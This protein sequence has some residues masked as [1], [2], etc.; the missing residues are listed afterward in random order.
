MIFKVALSNGEFEFNLH[1]NL[2]EAIEDLVDRNTAAGR[3][4]KIG[5]QDKTLA[6]FTLTYPSINRTL[7]GTIG[8][9]MLRRNAIDPNDALPYVPAF[10]K[11]KKKNLSMQEICR[12]LGITW[13]MATMVARVAKQKKK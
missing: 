4:V 12:R 11:L 7:E 2:K 1:K 9:A 6:Q 8:K 10:K 5:E 13:T 3:E